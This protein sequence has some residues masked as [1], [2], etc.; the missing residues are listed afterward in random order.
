MFTTA[1]KKG[2]TKKI[3]TQALNHTFPE[4]HIPWAYVLMLVVLV[5][6]VTAFK[7]PC[8]LLTDCYTIQIWY[9]FFYHVNMSLPIEV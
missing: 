1:K 9:T 2:E 6:M 8:Q 3:L 4:P 5:F 7:C